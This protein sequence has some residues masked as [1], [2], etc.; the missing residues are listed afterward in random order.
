MNDKSTSQHDNN[1]WWQSFHVIEMADLFL[2]RPQTQVDQTTDFLMEAMDLKQGDLVF[3]QCCGVGTLA[4]NLARRN[5]R[6]TGVE[7]D[8]RLF[9][10][11]PA[12]AH[13]IGTAVSATQTTTNEINR[14]FNERSSA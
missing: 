7:T 4:L 14:C 9:Q 3:D 10:R 5:L 2:D 13:S 1:D 6:A 11:K 12:M 8:L